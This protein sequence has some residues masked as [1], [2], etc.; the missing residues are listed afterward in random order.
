LA[1]YLVPEYF[2]RVV[3]SVRVVS[4]FDEHAHV[5]TTPTLALK[6]GH[7]LKEKECASLEMD[8]CSVQSTASAMER[9]K[10]INCSCPSVSVSGVG[11]FR[12]MRCDLY[13]RGNSTSQQFC[14]SRKM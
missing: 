14:L 12:R 2:D 1:D 5:Y 6:I 10:N 8:R 11:K 9:R 7:S 13:I 3:T 4:G